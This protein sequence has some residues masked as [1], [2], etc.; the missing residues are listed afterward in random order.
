MRFWARAQRM[1]TF[2]R[3]PDDNWVMIADIVLWIIAGLS[4]P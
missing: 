3:D 1:N 4:G 2:T